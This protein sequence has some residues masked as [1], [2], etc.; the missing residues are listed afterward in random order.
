MADLE[1]AIDAHKE[2][3]NCYCH[4]GARARLERDWKAVDVWCRK[5]NAKIH[6]LVLEINREDARNAPKPEEPTPTLTALT[7]EQKARLFDRLIS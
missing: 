4:N 7:Q 5:C 2:T 1:Q 6:R 3:C